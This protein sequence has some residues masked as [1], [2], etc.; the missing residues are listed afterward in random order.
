M[1]DIEA[2]R[3]LS[4]AAT[5]HG[6]GYADG[7]SWYRIPEKFEILGG[8]TDG[9]GYRDT[10]VICVD[11]DDPEG[12]IGMSDADADFI[13]AAANFVRSLLASS[14]VPGDPSPGADKETP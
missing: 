6:F 8:D 2:L 13:V 1:A 12:S 14:A 7:W 11:R 3:A 5:P 9:D 4:E 10:T